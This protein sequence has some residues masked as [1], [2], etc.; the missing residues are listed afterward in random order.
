M[1]INVSVKLDC[2]ELMAA[3]LALAEALPQM[4]IG[5]A[6]KENAKLITTEAKQ[7]E[8]PSEEIVQPVTT[9]V[10]NKVA[11]EDVRSKLATLSQAGKQKEVKALINKFG[12]KKLTEIPEDKYPQLLKEAE[13]I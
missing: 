13:E 3:I 8:K 11:I 4:G 12:A 1:N 2:P 7:M 9:E 5:A 10:A 6:V